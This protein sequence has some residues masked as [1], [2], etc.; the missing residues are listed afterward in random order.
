MNSSLL[1][2]QGMVAQKRRQSH[3]IRRSHQ[4]QTS[5]P[6]LTLSSSSS[7]DF[8][9]PTLIESKPRQVNTRDTRPADSIR[10]KLGY[11]LQKF[12]RP[13]QDDI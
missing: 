5:R 8:R 7:D 2:H 1:Y 11:I 4:T 3:S 9:T 13:R 10:S 12:W 6:S